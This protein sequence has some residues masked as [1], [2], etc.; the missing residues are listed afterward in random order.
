MVYVSC[1]GLQ[2]AATH[3]NLS[4]HNTCAYQQGHVNDLSYFYLF[5]IL[6]HIHASVPFGSLF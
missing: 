1:V 2:H 6:H 3:G 4:V 5:I